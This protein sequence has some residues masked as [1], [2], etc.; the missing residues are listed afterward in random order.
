MQAGISRLFFLQSMS[1]ET[2]SLLLSCISLCSSW[3]LISK[4]V[5]KE[6]GTLILHLILPGFP[7]SPLASIYYIALKVSFKKHRVYCSLLLEIQAI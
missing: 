5:P 4:T 7:Y 2:E 3:D 6:E 1:E